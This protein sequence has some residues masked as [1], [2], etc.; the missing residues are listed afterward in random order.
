MGGSRAAYACGMLMPTLGHARYT[1]DSCSASRAGE[2]SRGVGL[3]GF[4][5]GLW[6][7]SASV[8]LPAPTNPFAIDV[9]K[10]E[11][12]NAYRSGLRAISL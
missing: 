10:E 1:Q 5:S 12:P 4:E 8:P 3:R 9:K 11:L 6:T 7:R 2:L